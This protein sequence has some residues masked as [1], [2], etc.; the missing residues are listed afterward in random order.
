MQTSLSIVLTHGSARVSPS[1]RD[2]SRIMKVFKDE[3]LSIDDHLS[4]DESTLLTQVSSGMKKNLLRDRLLFFLIIALSAVLRFYEFPSL[5]SG[6]SSDEVSAGYETY[7]LLLH[8][9]DRWGNKFPVYF[10]GWGSGQNVLL[11]YLNIPFIKFFGLTIFAERFSSALLGLLTI[12]VFYA[13]MKK[14]YGTRTALIAAFFLGTYPWHVVI[15]RYSLESN[16]LPCF[17]LFG[18]ASLSYCYTSKYSRILIPF[19]LLFLAI[20]FY[21]YGVSIIVIPGILTLYFFFTSKK[22][23]WRNKIGF[24]LSLILFFL[25]AS[26][27]LIFI[28]DNFILHR[29]PPIIQ[30]LPFTIPL[31]ISSRLTQVRAGQNILAWNTLYITNQLNDPLVPAIGLITLPWI[32]IGI[33]DSLRKCNVYA[34]LLVIWL[35]STIPFFFIFPV[36]IARLNAVFI[37]LVGLSAIGISGLYDAIDKRDTKKA[38]LLLVLATAIIYNGLFYFDYFTYYNEQAWSSFN[39]G[40]DTALMR[41][42][43][44]A[45]AKEPIYVSNQL[46]PHLSFVYVLFFLKIDPVDFQKHSYV[47]VSYGTYQ[48]LQYRRY[49]FYSRDRGLTTSSSFVGIL[50]GQEQ[51]MCRRSKVLYM[52][53]GWR[54]VRCFNKRK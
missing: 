31:L 41:A 13:F 51:L 1:R 30:H 8:G 4:K 15:S 43:S 9:T 12:I 10:P 14:W 37:P 3:I 40:F 24:V 32:P 39:G 48:V 33:Y 7:A 35:I 34:N 22:E 54:V 52:G 21:A 18:I 5:P 50:K 53:Q 6:L 29:T 19:S 20:S 47:I 28:L 17:I 38:F 26:P 42:T 2:L 25:I 45:S 23:I 44:L 46:S 27:F 11:S 36:G 16:I 49:Y